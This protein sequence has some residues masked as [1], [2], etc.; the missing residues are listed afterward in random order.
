[1]TKAPCASAIRRAAILSLAIFSFHHV[2]FLQAQS[3]K[4]AAHVHFLL[5]IDTV[6]AAANAL[7]LDMDR[8]NIAKV[9]RD[10]M[11]ASSY[12]EGAGGKYSI[13]ILDGA[14]M[15]EKT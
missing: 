11:K 12:K 8:D 2:A 3:P 15:S 10:C 4:E 5:A 6:D 1:M 9:V 7:G 13:T 14:K